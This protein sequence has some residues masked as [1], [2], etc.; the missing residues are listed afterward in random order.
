M[1]LCCLGPLMNVR[2]V[3]VCVCVCVCERERETERETEKERHGIIRILTL[4]STLK[5]ICSPQQP[6]ESCAN[7]SEVCH[8]VRS[9]VHVSEP[10]PLNLPSALSRPLR[11]PTS[12]LGIHACPWSQGVS[13]ST[14]LQS[15]G[16]SQI[17]NVFKNSKF[18]QAIQELPRW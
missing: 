8:R 6:F 13:S 14:Y 10:R 2:G 1:C 17:C 3:C 16:Y 7:S 11:C 9:L 12:P 15:P 5:V 18:F 4:T